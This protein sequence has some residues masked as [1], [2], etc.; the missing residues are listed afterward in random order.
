M[1]QIYA[2][3]RLYR[4]KRQSIFEGFDAVLTAALA[5]LLII[6]TLL[7]YAA[8]RDWYARNGLDPQ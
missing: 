4:R 6:G 1:S 2:R 7:V 3:Q 8:T 5:L